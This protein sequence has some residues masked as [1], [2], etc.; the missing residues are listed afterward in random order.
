MNSAL[1]PR[2]IQARLRSGATL[3][4]VAEA[5]GVDEE[6]I[7]GFAGPVL[8]EREH[9]ASLALTST[10]RRRGESSTHR[11]LGELVKERLQQRSVDADKIEWDSWRQQDMRWRV[12]GTLEDDAGGRRAEFVFDHRSRYSVADN[13]DA[14]W[15]IGEEPPG[16][17]KE[18]ENTVDFDDELALL[19]ATREERPETVDSP[20]DD[21][22]G[23]SLMH[24]DFEDTSDL[25]TL[26]DMLSGISED[27]VRIYTGLDDDA[28]APES[29]DVEQPDDEA[30]QESE[31]TP[32][33]EPEPEPTPDPSDEGD[34]AD[35]E[36]TV[37]RRIVEDDIVEDKVREPVQDSLV[38]DPQAE[39][40]PKPKKRRRRA[41]VPSWD[42]IMF[43]GPK[44]K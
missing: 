12:V 42:E 21:V 34:S 14:R 36:P 10:V 5:A 26:Y 37:E 3:A 25:D 20:G 35:D 7:L 15:M 41:H 31:T 39:P 2:E 44:K 8:A 11:R 30:E 28:E 40:E 27:S 32:E 33:S 13:E 43:G 16:A 24:D 17:E 9:I 4:E 1:S 22:P 23:A 18:Q 6:A 19:R 29:D 38:D